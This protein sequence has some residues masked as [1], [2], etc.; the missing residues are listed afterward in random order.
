[1]DP[2]PSPGFSS[3]TPRGNTEPC[4]VHSHRWGLPVSHLALTASVGGCWGCDPELVHT[5]TSKPTPQASEAH[6]RGPKF[7]HYLLP[8]P[9]LH[10]HACTHMYKHPF[11]PQT[12]P[13]PE[14]TPLGTLQP[15]CQRMCASGS[16]SGKGAPGPDRFLALP[17]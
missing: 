6:V 13:P 11:S 16:L 4:E 10:T 15:C 5:A 8:G 14:G 17:F 9:C 7:L 12:S 2:G 3:A 1:M